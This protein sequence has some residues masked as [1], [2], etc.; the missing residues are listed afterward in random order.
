[1]LVIYA[2][3]R[4]GAGGGAR[5]RAGAVPA[6]VVLGAY[7]WVAF[8]APWRLSYQY[9]DN[10]FTSQQQQNL[11]GVGL[12]TGHG[13]WTLL[14]DGHGLLLVSPVLAAAAAGLVLLWHGLR[15]EADR[16]RRDRAHL[17]LSIRA[18]YFLPNGG[19]ARRG[20]GSRPR[21]CRSCCSACRSRS[22]AGAY[23]TLALAAA[24]GR[25]SRCSTS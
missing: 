6:G 11:F 14:I 22:C 21:R 18:G 23:V 8:G 2:A 17:R 3:L 25:R 24:L 16:R 15:L 5:V 19:P 13:I 7:D 1:M 4:G 12:P 20:R 9:T 10:I